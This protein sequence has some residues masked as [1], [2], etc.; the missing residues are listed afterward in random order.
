MK[1]VDDTYMYTIDL[2]VV[3]EL[4]GAV[5]RFVAHQPPNIYMCVCVCS[6][7]ILV[8]IFT[9]IGI[10]DLSENG[11]FEGETTLFLYIAKSFASLITMKIRKMCIQRKTKKS[12]AHTYI[13]I[14][15]FLST[16]SVPL[17]HITLTDF[18]F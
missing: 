18:H 8:S 12:R 13:Y 2:I 15:W 5:S 14:L 6:F 17:V 4:Q 10:T 11:I 16:R 1:S 3:N 7:Y 9:V